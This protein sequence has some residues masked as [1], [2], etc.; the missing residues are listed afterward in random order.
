MD[1]NKNYFKIKF[2]GQHID[3][4]LVYNQ[5]LP[6]L[7]TLISNDVTLDDVIA[8]LVAIKEENPMDERIVR[9]DE[10]WE[11][12]DPYGSDDKK[13]NKLFTEIAGPII[14]E[15][16]NCIPQID[17]DDLDLHFSWDVTSISG[18]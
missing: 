6:K 16:F 8:K 15:P 9:V 2:R 13:I 4:S 18:S 12:R 1:N 5:I 10:I 7:Q 3:S 14:K 11:N 17:D